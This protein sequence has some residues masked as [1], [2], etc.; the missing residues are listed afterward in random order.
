[1][2]INK[3]LNSGRKECSGL[4]KAADAILTLPRMMWLGKSVHIINTP[5]GGKV[6]H[7]KGAAP[8]ANF[9]K[10][11]KSRNYKA[12]ALA[13]ASIILSI[14]LAPVFGIGFLL[15]KIALIKD[16]KA[17]AYS[18]ATDAVWHKERL[19]GKKSCAVKNKQDA[20]KRIVQL[21]DQI[22]LI[23]AKPERREYLGVKNPEEVLSTQENASEYWQKRSVKLED[24]IASATDHVN[25]A[26]AA[27]QAVA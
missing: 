16:K 9:E 17:A 10:N 6:E 20:D 23:A 4:E 21:K 13:V 3:L 27:Y 12:V 15:K 1:M 7:E 5:E 22:E 25:Q 19:E 14:L 24:S 18:D 2:T 26:V 8:L 11:V